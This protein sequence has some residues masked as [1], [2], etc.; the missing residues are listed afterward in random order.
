MNS[1]HSG[2]TLIELLIVMVV[3]AVLAAIAFPAY[4]GQQRRSTRAA[5]QSQMV[6]IAN[7]Q[8]QYLLDARNYTLGAGALATL[9]VTLP[10]EVARFYTV[11]VENDSGGTA[12]TT[13]PTFTVRATPIAGTRQ[14]PDG[15]LTLAHN[16]AKTR[17]GNPGW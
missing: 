10:D 2:V 17:A 4:D 6:N 14:V 15:V 9:N 1:R 7:R 5:A 11:S 16:G 12:P 13:P 3:I 8:A